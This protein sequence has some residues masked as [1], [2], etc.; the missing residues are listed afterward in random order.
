MVHVGKGSSHGGEMDLA[1]AAAF[2]WRSNHNGLP[3]MRVHY[4]ASM[5]RVQSPESESGA[6]SENLY[7]IHC[8][9][10]YQSF[11]D[12]LSQVIRQALGLA[13]DISPQI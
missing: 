4:Y 5:S 3:S 6:A 13:G 10:K 1:L 8:T 2:K 11:F 7:K 12:I 9:L